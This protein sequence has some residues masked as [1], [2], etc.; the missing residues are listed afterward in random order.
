MFYLNNNAFLLNVVFPISRNNL[1]WIEY[2]L[3]F[4]VNTM[5]FPFIVIS[6]AAYNGVRN[7]T[8]I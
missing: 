6:S 1:E 4:I 5:V 2:G 8:T 3:V 7:T